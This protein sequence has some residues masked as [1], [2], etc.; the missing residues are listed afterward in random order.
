M[1]NF[2]KE[3]TLFSLWD[4]NCGLCTM[5]LGNYCLTWVSSARLT[6]TETVTA[7][8]RWLIPLASLYLRHQKRW[9][10]ADLWRRL[11]Q[12]GRT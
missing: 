8:G 2:S 3:E 9:Y 12:T 6:F 1:K 11:A 5:C 4:L 10:L 7:K